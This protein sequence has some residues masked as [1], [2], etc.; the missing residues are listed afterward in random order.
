MSNEAELPGDGEDMGD[1][2]RND[3]LLDEGLARQEIPEARLPDHVPPL[4]SDPQDDAG[5]LEPAD[6]VPSVAPAITEGTAWAHFV[7]VLYLMALLMLTS[8]GAGIAMRVTED[9][10]PF[11]EAVMGGVDA[12]LIL[13]FVCRE[14][15]A[16]RPALVQRVAT[17]SWLFTAALMAAMAGFMELYFFLG[18]YAFELYNSLDGFRNHGWPVWSAIVMIV[19]GP[20]I[21]EELAFRG[22][23]LARL[24]PLMGKRDA[25]LLQATLF[26]IMHLSVAILLSHFVMGLCFGLLRLRSGSL[27]PGMLAHGLW[28]LAVLIQDGLLDGW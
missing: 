22:F 19:I 14:W 23:L 6:Q 1:N 11:L 25:L 13:I 20:A 8:I 10:S 26:S 4:P 2:D 17:N 27:L 3:E 5:T 9:E 15:R 7:P 21:F 12:L 18:K 16:I 28:N 24:V